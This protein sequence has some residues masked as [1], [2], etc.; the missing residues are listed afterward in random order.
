MPEL[1]PPALPEPPSSPST[2][3]D[4]EPPS[5]P[6]PPLGSPVC[7]PVPT[8]PP[9]DEEMEMAG[10][11]GESPASPPGA[12]PHASPAPELGTFP[13]LPEE[14]EEEEEAPRLERE[15]TSGSSPP[16]SEEDALEEGRAGGDPEAKGSPLLLE[17]EELGPE[18]PME[19]CAAGEKLLGHRDEGGPEP[20]TLRPRPDILNEISN[21]S[22]GDTS[23]SFPGSEPLLGSPDPEGGGSL[24][25]ELGPALADASLQK[26]DAASLPLGAET[27][28]SLLFEPA[29][30]GDGDKSRRRSSPGRSRVKQ[31]LGGPRQPQSWRDP[32]PSLPL[33]RVGE[34]RACAG[35]WDGAVPLRC[36]CPGQDAWRGSG[37]A[38]SG[39]CNPP[40]PL[41]RRVAAAASRGG[42]APEVGP[43]GAGAGAVRA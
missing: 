7:A 29:A 16:L 30:K 1:R 14:E 28:D 33:R 37:W 40:S 34:G 36:P 43:T 17:P 9:E 23:S 12:A 26:E 8:E 13:G 6:P 42:G 2:A 25:L 39:C 3:M 15:G 32:P 19:V 41:G 35:G 27:D 18:T 10:G 24:S 22:Q 38:P 20:P 21:L 5:S 11:E 31:V 4:T